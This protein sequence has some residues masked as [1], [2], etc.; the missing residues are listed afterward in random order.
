VIATGGTGPVI[1]Q[2]AKNAGKA[3]AKQAVRQAVKNNNPFSK[4]ARTPG[5]KIDFLKQ[6]AKNDK[7]PSW[8]K[9]WLEQGR[10][11]PGYDVDHILPLSVGGAH[12]PFNMRLVLRSDHRTHHKYYDPWNWK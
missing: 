6:Q 4:A 5:P 11:P 10:N 8:M 12:D 9:T 2:V 7:T 1:V 3:A